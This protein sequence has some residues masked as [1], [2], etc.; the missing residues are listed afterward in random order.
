MSKT[1]VWKGSKAV[2]VALVMGIF[3]LLSLGKRTSAEELKPFCASKVTVYFSTYRTTGSFLENHSILIGNLKPNAKITNIKSGNKKLKVYKNIYNPDDHSLSLELRGTQSG[4]IYKNATLKDN[5]KA[6]VTFNVKQG[7]KTYK[8]KCTVVFKAEPNPLKS[9][10]IAGKTSKK[11]SKSSLTI[12]GHAVTVD[13]IKSSK[14]KIKLNLKPGYKLVKAQAEYYKTGWARSETKAFKNGGSVN[15]KC[16]GG[17]LCAIY[18]TC[19]KEEDR[20]GI[21][22]E[23]DM[24]DMMVKQYAPT[25]NIELKFK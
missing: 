5:E 13:K 3:L 17:S 8:L 12:T 11:F 19:Y 21:A 1:K 14:V 16:Q 9:V 25:F 4:R 20:Q 24:K 2:W 18:I 10:Q 23:K 7:G 22:T 15:T 6:K